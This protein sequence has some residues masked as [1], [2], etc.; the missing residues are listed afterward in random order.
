[1]TGVGFLGAGIIFVRRDS[2]RGLTTAAAI[3]LT[4]AV[5]AAS[6]AGLWVLAV[7][8]TGIYF[9]V[10]LAFPAMTGRL[11]GRRPRSRRCKSATRTA[12]ASC[13]RCSRQPPSEASRSM[14]SRPRRWADGHRPD[15][16]WWRWLCTSMA[17]SQSTSLRLCSR[18]LTTLM[19]SWPATST[20]ST[21]KHPRP[22]IWTMTRRLARCAAY[23]PESY[24]VK[25]P[26]D[27]FQ[28]D[29]P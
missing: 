13:G 2:V 19:W 11:P 14:T 8:T 9:L 16:R 22:V 15:R 10:A 3:W 21:S 7:L 6:G 24:M 23:V 17:G 20:P 26:P 18:S 4:A 27:A 5:G 29:M 12:G 25:K 1:V 28:E